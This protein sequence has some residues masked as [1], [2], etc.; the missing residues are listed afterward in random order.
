MSEVSI[1]VRLIE[2]GGGG[3]VL[4]EVHGDGDITPMQA[5]S[6]ID[7]AVGA[8]QR[9]VRDWNTE[10]RTLR[11]RQIEEESGGKVISPWRPWRSIA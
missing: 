2:I 5:V 4:A 10:S 11:Q 9:R 3:F 7:E 6:T 1:T 8:I